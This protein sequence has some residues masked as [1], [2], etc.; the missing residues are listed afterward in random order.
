MKEIDY[1]KLDPDELEIDP[2]NERKSNVQP[3]KG[4]NS[5]VDSV[6]KKG[7]IQPIVV[8]ER[9]GNYYVV[10]GQRRTLAAQIAGID[11][12]PARVMEMNDAEARVVS[13]TEN[14]EPF[15]KSVPLDDR[16]K[17]I[18]SLHDEEGWSQAK[19]AEK[20]D[21]SQ[22][23][24]SRWMEPVHPEWAGTPIDPDE[25]GEVNAGDIPIGSLKHIRENTDSKAKREDL[26]K[27]VKEK[28]IK[29]SLVKRAARRGSDEDDFEERLED[30]SEELQDGEETVKTS[31]RF[32]GDEAEQIKHVM[33]EYGKPRDE[34]IEELTRKGLQ[35]IG[36]LD[37]PTAQ[38]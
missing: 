15:N 21:V 26:V 18:R 30:I 23:T 35:K 36:L 37:Q 28:N 5:L 2:V 32:A 14:A 25:D 34:V 22:P 4:E 1:L 27:F 11:D 17:A 13:I 16:A 19:I 29:E 9:D 24:I 38:Q 12:I 3:Q 7:V 10:A 31:V 8:R 6:R 33:K 20:L